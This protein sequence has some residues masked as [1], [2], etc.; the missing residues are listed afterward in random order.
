[1]E[2]RCRDYRLTSGGD[3]PVVPQQN[4]LRACES[5]EQARRLLYDQ[6]E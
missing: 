5:N 6:W 3:Q 1:M 2:K 4:F